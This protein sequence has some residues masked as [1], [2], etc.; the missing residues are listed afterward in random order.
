MG[1]YMNGGMKE[2][3]GLKCYVYADDTMTNKLQDFLEREF[4]IFANVLA[5]L[6]SNSKDSIGS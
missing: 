3:C 4:T 1:K 2:S 5:P 6:S